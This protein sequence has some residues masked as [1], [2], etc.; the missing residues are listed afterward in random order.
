MAKP[1][2]L[3]TTLPALPSIVGPPDQRMINRTAMKATWADPADTAVNARSGHRV[4]GFRSFDVLRKLLGNPASGV[5]EAHVIAADQL[6]RLHDV[7]AFGLTGQGGGLD[8]PVNMLNYGPVAGPPMTAV[9]RAE[10]E[11]GYARAMRIFDDEQASIVKVV[12]LESRAIAVWQREHDT[13][14]ARAKALLLGT[15]AARGAMLGPFENLS[16]LGPPTKGGP[17]SVL[18]SRGAPLVGDGGRRVSPRRPFTRRAWDGAA[19]SGA[20]TATPEP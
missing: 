4:V 10:A 2:R 7:V 8:M 3:H 16:C 14:H 18:G 11:R 19:G 1:R 13:S 12:I 20:A 15:A 17:F 6:R 5:I 9:R